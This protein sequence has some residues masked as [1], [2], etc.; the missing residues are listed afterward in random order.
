MKLHNWAVAFGL[1][2]LAGVAG[3][4]GNVMSITDNALT[5][6]TGG[7]PAVAGTDYKL[8]QVNPSNPAQL[9][10]NDSLAVSSVLSGPKT[11]TSPG[12]NIR[13]YA[14][15][16]TATLSAFQTAPHVALNGT[17]GGHSVSVSSLNGADWFGT[18]DNTA[19]LAPTL[20]NTWFNSFLSYYNF[21][22]FLGSNG[23]SPT[24][25]AVEEST[26]FNGFVNNP[27][28]NGGGF[29]H[30]SGPSVSYVQEDSSTNQ[31][32]IGIADTDGY[33]YGFI[34]A[35]V[36]ATATSSTYNNFLATYPDIYASKVALVS[37][38]GGTPQ[39]YYSFSSVPS[40]LTTTDPTESYNIEFQ[41]TVP[42][43]E[44]ASMG[45]IGSAAAMLLMRRRRERM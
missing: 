35:Y 8:Y 18:A 1:A 19:Y 27:P 45:L 34:K 31:L 21:T 4:R 26:L 42:V 5:V 12:G 36:Q 29:Q 39:A 2:V 6:T 10:E 37:V 11:Q 30:L 14:G 40:G 22:G 24:A 38:D 28:S 17:I 15:S 7:S 9:I 20:A 43:P 32:S 25:I 33:L 13:L 16:D 3:V 41:D 23:Y 44:P